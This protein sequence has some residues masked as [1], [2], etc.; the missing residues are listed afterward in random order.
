MIEQTYFLDMIPGE[1]TPPVVHVSQFDVKSRTLTFNLMKGGVAYVPDAGMS[2]TL[3]GMKPDNTVFSYPMTV[4]GSSVSIDVLTQMTVVS[5]HVRCEVSVSNQTGKIGSANFILA[6][7]ESPID[8]GSISES[9]IPIFEDL[10]NQAQQA[11]ASAE[12]SASDAEGFATDAETAATSVSAI[13]PASAGTTG[14]VLTKTAT[15]AD[16]V[17]NQGL[18]STGTTGQI[19]TKTATGSE[20]ANK[21]PS[22]GTTGQVLTKTAT[23]EA[24]EDVDGLPAGGTTGQVLTKNSSTSGD[25]SWQDVDGLPSGGT[26]GQVLTKNSS[27]DGDA[28]WQTPQSGGG[29][30]GSITGTLSDQTD[31]QNA[32]NAKANTSTLATVESTTTA[33]KAY[34]V[35]DYLVYNGIL[36]KVISAIDSGET[37]TPNTN[38]EATTAG[39]ELTSLNN[40]LAAPLLWTN[41][42]PSTNFSPQTLSIDLSDYEFVEIVVKDSTSTNYSKAV[43]GK[44]GLPIT[45]E[46][47]GY[48]SSFTHQFRFATPS[49]TGITFTKGSLTGSASEHNELMIP[50]FIYGAK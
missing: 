22:S 46:A 15:G 5:G 12:Q 10:K 49:D 19:L 14:Q 16:W 4:D 29:T 2:V 11:A 45:L 18:P 47:F 40:G 41:P 43:K 6:V 32:L 48:G 26:A 28:S 13:L 38:I 39:A 44:K 33:S 1:S 25:A 24:W 9:D 30:W 17:D 37:L 34:A 20:W 42:S 23:G 36:Y 35:G 50:L 31:L 3:D 7:E 21:Y 8:S 27:T